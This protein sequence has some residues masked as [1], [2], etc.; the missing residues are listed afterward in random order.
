MEDCERGRVCDDLD[1]IRD[2]DRERARVPL[3][4]DKDNSRPVRP[5]F[6]DRRRDSDDTF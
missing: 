4:A 5:L 1:L 3:E 2:L 6:D